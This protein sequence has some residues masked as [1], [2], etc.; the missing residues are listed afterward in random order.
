MRWI[1]QMAALA[2]LGPAQGSIERPS[3]VIVGQHPAVRLSGTPGVDL[4][5]GE[6]QQRRPIPAPSV[7][8][9][10]AEVVHS[11]S[12]EGDIADGTSG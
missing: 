6:F 11:L 8:W 3:R 5:A 9:Y 10:D 1:L 4:H 2:R 12:I 7:L